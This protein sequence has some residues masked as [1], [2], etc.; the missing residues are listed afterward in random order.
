[1]SVLTALSFAAYEFRL[2]SLKT[3]LTN[4]LVEA[5][6]KADK[7]SKTAPREAVP[8]PLRVVWKLEEA[9][10]AEC[11]EDSWV[12]CCI[13][14]MV[15]CSLRWSDCQR[16]QVDT[17]SKSEGIIRGWCRRTKSCPRGMAWG[18]VMGGA[19]KSDWGSFFYSG[20]QSL[21]PKQDF[22]IAACSGK[23]LAYCAM[24]GHFRRILWTY[25]G[26][27]RDEAAVFSLHS[28]K[29]TLLSWANQLLLDEATRAKQGHHVLPTMS[30][31]VPKYGRDDIVGQIRRQREALAA[32]H[33]GWIPCTPLNRGLQ[34]L[35]EKLDT[36]PTPACDEAS[37][38]E[39]ESEGEEV[40][41]SSQSDSGSEDSEEE[42]PIIAFDGLWMINITTGWYHKAIHDI[43]GTSWRPACRA[44]SN[45]KAKFELRE[46]NPCFQ[47]WTP[48]AHSACK[49]ARG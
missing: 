23:P 33:K 16:V 10:K 1:M 4:P 38:T 31:A 49:S 5:W 17:I 25:G 8:L 6:R 41:A 26:L 22:L 27:S 36:S 29:C 19:S 12:L 37:D 24:L 7:W 15:W 2:S 3:C 43:T 47:G 21:R 32:I 14:L 18:C 35:P 28:C 44:L 46:T 20:L 39:P 42:S 13:L 9:L 34:P 30:K 45:A 11:G 48:C 40:L